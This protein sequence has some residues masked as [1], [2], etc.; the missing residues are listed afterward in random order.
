MD[1]STETTEATEATALPFS[2]ATDDLEA[3]TKRE[4]RALAVGAGITIGERASKG[5]II[6]IL[7]DGD[8]SD[9]EDGSSAADVQLYKLVT[10][11][12]DAQ[13][14]KGI[15]EIIVVEVGVLTDATEAQIEAAALKRA[16]ELRPIDSQATPAFVVPR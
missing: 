11:E 10:R 7:L 15:R 3:L 2:S 13:I 16:Y 6:S 5:D 9:P 8:L 4:L 14:L 12:V 1:E